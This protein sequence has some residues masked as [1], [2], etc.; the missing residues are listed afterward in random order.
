M[1]LS[2][3]SLLV[4]L[5]G[6]SWALI[7]TDWKTLN[8][9]VTLKY[10]SPDQYY[11]SQDPEEI[12]REMGA[13]ITCRAAD[14][15][16]SFSVTVPSNF[17]PELPVKMLTHG[18]AST[19]AGAG[20]CSAV[21]AWMERYSKAVGVALVDWANLASFTGFGDWDNYV[22][23]WSARNSIDVGEF[24]GSCL[25][26]LSVQ[27]NIKGENIHIV[28]HSL[29]SHLMGKA[30]RTFAANQ[31]NSELVGRISGLDPAGPHFVD[32][33]Y[34]D[35][36]PELA[37]NILSKESAAF[38][39]VIHTNG[40]F[41][42]WVVCTTFRSGT[43]LQLGHM[44]FYPDGGSVQS[45]CLFGIDARPGGLCS[46]NRATQYFVNSIREPFLF[47]AVNCASVE[48]CNQEIA[49]TDQIS[50]YM[51]E[52]AMNYWDGQS[53]SLFYHDLEYCHWTYYDYS[54]WMCLK[55]EEDM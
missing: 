6:P 38:V 40:G 23:N 43:I 17:H 34:V 33:P 52:G 15:G 8:R 26:E 54:N 50:G 12:W 10:F 51:G 20:Q 49:T 32:G 18:F 45:G 22:Y 27:Q 14:D 31:Q 25:A 16:S 48:E 3:L 44:D 36:I 28:G 39:D 5:I 41:E 47:P 19:V 21:E 30:G 2:G 42:P 29:G 13:N 53:R 1:I 11:F 35:A 4:L 9:E 46:H 55:N 37:E 24:V 7:N